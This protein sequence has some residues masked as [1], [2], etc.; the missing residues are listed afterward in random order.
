MI[1]SVVRPVGTGL[2]V[3]GHLTRMSLMAK[4]GGRGRARLPNGFRDFSGKRR[5]CAARFHSPK[6]ILQTVDQCQRDS[7]FFFE[8]RSVRV[9]VIMALPRFWVE[10]AAEATMPSFS[11]GVADKEKFPLRAPIQ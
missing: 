6:K 2:P 8:R 4:C 10:T 7:S 3:C 5:G 9:S 11:N 1:T